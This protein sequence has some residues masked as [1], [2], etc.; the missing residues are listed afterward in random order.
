MDYHSHLFRCQKQRENTFDKTQ[1]PFISLGGIK[2]TG[3]YLI[4]IKPIYGKPT[5]N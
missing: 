1:H 4:I 2:D 5:S 3:T